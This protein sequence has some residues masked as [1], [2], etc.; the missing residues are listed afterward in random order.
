[1]DS[2][3]IISLAN[4]SNIVTVEVTAEDAVTTR[5]Y[6]VT[7][8]RGDESQ[9]SS[10][11]E[12]TIGICSRTAKVQE[13]ILAKLNEGLDAP[14]FSHCS[15]VTDDLGAITG[16]LR[17]SNEEIS[18][19]RTG[20]FKGLSNLESLYLD[21][22]SLSALPDD[23]F[24]GLE[25]LDILWLHFNP[26]S[27]FSLTMELEQ[28]SDDSVRVKVDEGTPF[29]MSITLSASGGTL[30]STDVTVEAGDI[31]SE[32]VV[33]TPDV[34]ST[35]VTVSVASS[36]IPGT[37]YTNYFGLVWQEAEPLAI[38]FEAEIVTPGLVLG[39]LPTDDPPVNFRITSYDEDEVS[40]AWEIPHNRG[41]T[42][43]VLERYDHDGTE[44]VSSEWSVSGSVAGVASVTESGSNLTDNWI[45][46]S[47][48]R[49]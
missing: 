31:K 13:A 33:M 3:G 7:V 12:S 24:E 36:D 47:Y 29:E 37:G 48:I 30:S 5:V 22:N 38:T 27:P 16:S 20:D 35:E 15:E 43:Y 8:T 2:D 34:G 17:I 40:L 6:T 32:S 10:T 46:E 23:I 41:V 21:H 19:L 49:I 42:D 14:E 11:S 45:Y 39:E 1:M 28:V 18:S 26:G 4:G 9:P 44:F 25:S